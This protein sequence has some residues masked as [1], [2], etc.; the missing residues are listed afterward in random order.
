MIRVLNEPSFFKIKWN[1]QKKEYASRKHSH[2][3][4]S[5]GL[6]L[7]GSTNVSVKDS[8][9]KLSPGDFILIPAQTAHLCRP[10][11]PDIFN[12]LLV[13]IDSEWWEKKLKV[14]AEKIPSKML[15][16]PEEWIGILKS[17]INDEPSELEIEKEVISFFESIIP[18]NTL[19]KTTAKKDD[20]LALAGNMIKANPEKPLSIDAL[21]DIAEMS[22]YSFIRKYNKSFGLTPHA[23]IVNKRIQKAIELLGTSKSLTD[24]A[25]ECG[26]T[27]QSHFIKQFKL[28]CGMRPSEYRNAILYNSY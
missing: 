24:I 13:Y 3:E 17:I 10:E 28:H 2:K 12:F 6:I 4:V 26:F 1:S 15:Q 22:K 18:Q 9:Y 25:I 27:D 16:A 7:N 11:Q 21:A 20:K 23:D 19:N 5:A 8:T 14:D